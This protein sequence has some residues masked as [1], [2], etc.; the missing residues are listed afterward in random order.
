MKIVGQLKAILGLDK[1][2]YDKGLK[3]AKKSTQSFG[4][5][6]KKLG[7]MIAGVFAFR[8]VLRGVGN[9]IKKNA[10][11]GQS[12][13]DLSAITGAT[14]KDLKFYEQQALDIGKSTTLSAG[15]AVKAFELMGSARPELLKN[16]EALAAVTKE[17]VVL[18]EAAGIELPVATQ[19]LA[20]AMNQFNVPA[21]EA[22]R[23]INVL[24]AGS[25]AG[26][27][28]IP[29]ITDAIKVMG[30]AANMAGISLEQSVGA[31]ETLAEKGISGAESGTQLRKVI[32]KLQSG[33]DKFNP[34]VVG[35]QKALENLGKENLS[36]ADLTQMF[37]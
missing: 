23:V 10:E 35:L 16:Q 12:L 4:N 2:K 32:L 5:S 13:A 6:V 18:A 15:Q 37:G 29:G 11:F 7:G 30:T 21:N 20:K 36:A 27:E 8:Q 34:K 24:A 28:A 17:A 9:V 1:S 26:A 3:G 14:G 25:K 22:G 31:I 33:A 19:S